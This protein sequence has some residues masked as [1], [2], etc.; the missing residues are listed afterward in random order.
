MKTET[1]TFSLPAIGTL[2]NYVMPSIVVGGVELAPMK[3]YPVKVIAHIGT[4][5]VQLQETACER[6]LINTHFQCFE[7]A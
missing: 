5:G 7:Q 3:K 6:L 4:Y 1:P 2:G